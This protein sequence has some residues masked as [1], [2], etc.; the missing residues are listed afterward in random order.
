MITGVDYIFLSNIPP[1]NV[2]PKFISQLQLLWKKPVLE[3]FDRLPAYIEM[4]FC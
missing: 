4:F 1:N 2:E 3:E